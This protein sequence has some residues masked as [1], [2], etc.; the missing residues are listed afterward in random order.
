MGLTDIP[1]GAATAG[2]YAA[3]FGLALFVNEGRFWR[4]VLF[5]GSM[6]T[7]CT[8]IYLSQVRS[9]LAMLVLSGLGFVGLLLRRDLSSQ[10]VRA[11]VRFPRSVGRIRL[12]PMVAAVCGTALIGLSFAIAIGGR[13]V[14][15]RFTTVTPGS[16]SETYQ[17]S[18]GHFFIDT[19]EELLPRYPLGAG[20]GRWG[21]MNYYFGDRASSLWAEIQW[22]AWLYD[23]GVPLMLAYFL[24]LAMTLRSASKV[25]LR[26]Y[27]SEIAVFATTIFA[28]G[29]GALG[30]T[31]DYPFFL[32]QGGLDFWL[33]SAM[34]FTA[35][36]SQTVHSRTVVA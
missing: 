9:V 35:V 29:L 26:A 20:L 11:R 13:A 6:L 5:A 16:F 24:A 25:A 12:I 31:F 23:G 7:G 14:T 18:R 21:M 34:L 8:V 33:L 1:G 28:Y 4:K 19:V 2:M 15:D 3:M 30:M 17:Q 22:T 32:S 36:A 10:V 27:D